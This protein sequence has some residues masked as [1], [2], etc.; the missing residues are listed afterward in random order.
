VAFVDVVGGAVVIRGEVAGLVLA[1]KLKVG[2]SCQWH[3]ANTWCPQDLDTVIFDAMVVA[4]SSAVAL[5]IEKT[6]RTDSTR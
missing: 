3:I 5:T 1:I 4:V 6:L 2:L